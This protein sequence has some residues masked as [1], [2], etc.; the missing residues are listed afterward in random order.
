MKIS[1]AS[2]NYDNH[3]FVS[4]FSKVDDPRRTNKG[5][6]KHYLTDMIF[7]VVSA[8]VCGADDWKSIYTFGVSQLEWLRKFG[9][10]TKGIPSRDTMSRVFAALDH[11]QLN[12][13][14]IEWAQSVSK[15]SDGEVVAIDGKRIKRSY[16]KQSNKNAIHMVTAFACENGISLGQVATEE[17]SNEITA[18]PKL[19]D[20]LTIAGTTV[21]I[22]AM[23]C[24]TDIAGKIIDKEADY[25]LAVKEN[26]KELY[27][28]VKKVFKITEERD[29]HEDTDSG[30]GRI[31]TR[32]CSVIDN[33]DFL[34][35]KENWNELKTIVMVE[36]EQHDLLTQKQTKEVRYYISSSQMDAEKFNRSIRSHWYIE[37][38]LHW[39]LDVDFK[40]DYSRKR[41]GSSASNFNVLT[42]VAM[43]YLKNGEVNRNTSLAANRFKAALDTKFREKILNL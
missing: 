9:C 39:V 38:K 6:I 36:S 16:D 33:L 31:E 42:K 25:I 34:D 15:L 11:S 12:S 30:H 4:F 20:M 22:D 1:G 18:I 7:L 28:Q 35:G 14:F 13:C 8:V 23:G 40:E 26:Q 41:N 27:A 21:T 17:K 32:V 19:L 37:N 2:K 24:Q 43:A 29:R 10:F 5:N 3:H